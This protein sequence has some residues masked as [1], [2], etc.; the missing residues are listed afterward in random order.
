MHTNTHALRLTFSSAAV[1]D[2]ARSPFK[3]LDVAIRPAE[4]PSASSPLNSIAPEGCFCAPANRVL[5]SAEVFA[6]LTFSA[7]LSS[8]AI[9]SESAWNASPGHR[10]REKH[11][12][13]QSQSSKLPWQHHCH[14]AL[15]AR[16]AECL[17]LLALVAHCPSLF[18]SAMIP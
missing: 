9:A 14:R 18:F 1:S 5:R 8:R 17:L 6:I 13:L 16:P 7:H 4:L 3:T 11:A 10:E 12:R 15:P 2:R